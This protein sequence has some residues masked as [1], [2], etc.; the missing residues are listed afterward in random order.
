MACSFLL[1]GLLTIPHNEISTAGLQGVLSIP[2]DL[3]IIKCCI[4]VQG[5]S[6][7]GFLLG[8]QS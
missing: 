4:H 2:E 7:V 3:S 1:C 5:I 6:S 8:A